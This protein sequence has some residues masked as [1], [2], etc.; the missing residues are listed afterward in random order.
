[1]YD[2][3]IKELL[4]I[5]VQCLIQKNRKKLHLYTQLIYNISLNK[6]NNEIEKQ[7]EEEEDRKKDILN[8]FFVKL[9]TKRGKW[10]AKYMAVQ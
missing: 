2:E 1:M 10:N 6:S 8:K 3:A 4:Y 7:I 9:C 5:H